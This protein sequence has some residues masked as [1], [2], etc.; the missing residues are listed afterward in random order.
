MEKA[1]FFLLVSFFIQQQTFVFHF[2]IF[3]FLE[4]FLEE[5]CAVRIL[6]QRNVMMKRILTF[7]F[8]KLKEIFVVLL[9][10]GWKLEGD[11]THEKPPSTRKLQKNF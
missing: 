8:G 2:N 10:L 1:S 3:F 9:R 11:S 7:F 4:E 5:I 6:S